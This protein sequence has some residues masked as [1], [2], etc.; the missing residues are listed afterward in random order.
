MQRRN[1]LALL[2]GLFVVSMVIAGCGGGGGSATLSISGSL[3]GTG[4]VAVAYSGTLN[5]SGGTTP[6]TWTATGLPPGVTGSSANTATLTVGGTPTKA[7][8]YNVNIKVVDTNSNTTAYSVTIV[9][10]QPATP[11]ISGTFPV[12]GNVGTA[13]S[14]SLTASGGTPPYTWTVTGLPTGVTSSGANSSTFSVSGTPTATGT[15]AVDVT[16]TDSLAGTSFYNVSVVI[17]GPQPPTI[18]GALPATG[19]VNIPYSGSLT[20]VG[21]VAPYTWVVTGLPAGVTASGTTTPTL[22][23][24]GTPTAA[25]TDAVSVK[26][27]DSNANSATYAV[28]I[29]VSPPIGQTLTISPT[30]LGVLNNGVAVTPILVTSSPSSTAPYTWTVS[31]GALPAGLVLN[32]GTTSNATTITSTTNSITITGTP[33]TTGAYS[34]T[35]AI[36]DSASPAGTGSQAYVGAVNDPVCSA[37]PQ[38]RGNEAALMTTTPFAFL[39]KGSGS[40]QGPVYWAGSFTP[41]GSG[42]ITAGDIDFLSQTDGPASYQLS[43]AG[44]SYSYGADGRGCLNLAYGNTA[45]TYSF[46]LGAG[47]Q[48]GRIEEFD[49]L[50][51]KIAAAGQMHQQTPSAFGLS[52]LASNFAFGLDGWLVGGGGTGRTAM[53]GTVANSTTGV[54]SNGFA[55]L[56][57]GGG[58]ESALTGGSGTLANTTISS[59]TG[60]GTGSFTIPTTAGSLVFSFAYYV[61][62]GSDLYIV[63]TD[64]ATAGNYLLAGRAVKAAATAALS[65]GYYLPVLSGVNGSG[66]NVVTIGTMSALLTKTGPTT[67]TTIPLA[68]FYSNDGGSYTTQAYTAGTYSLTPTSGR[69]TFSGLGSTPP[70]AYLTTPTAGEDGIAG[71]LVGTDT[72]TSAGTLVLQ[73][74]TKPNFYLSDIT[75]NYAVGTGEDIGGTTGSKV[76]AFTFNGSGGY[77]AILDVVGVGE[78]AS[79]PNQSAGGTIA[80]SNTNDGS[81]SFDGGSKTLVTNGALVFAID[82]T[83]SQPQLYLFIQQATAK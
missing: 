82:A 77:S 54:L 66:Q 25:A 14:G 18:S 10:A 71:F 68:T 32:N 69:V 35:L 9:I 75:G 58:V 53:A 20:V 2:L 60:R 79:E 31:S 28:S 41:N 57:V 27:T 50:T 43:V 72:S 6:Y 13:Y 78:T 44:S 12:T 15:F 37:T 40:G 67:F 83:G 19:A 63:S 73:G 11:V 81:G 64:P 62:N 23:V 47:G 8:S 5:V 56:N 48:V 34:F 45:V 39:L 7:G 29:V 17:A 49:Y 80:I 70:V 33:T 42:G 76:G 46:S 3:P 22:T 4:T 24:S 38:L 59:T 16:L 30:T 65:N 26:V 36:T 61:I 55:D 74:L 52:S 1:T 51:S 21:G